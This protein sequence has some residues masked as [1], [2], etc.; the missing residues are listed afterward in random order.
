MSQDCT[1]DKLFVFPCHRHQMGWTPNLATAICTYSLYTHHSRPYPPPLVLI[2]RPHPYYSMPPTPSSPL[3]P[4]SRPKPSGPFQW[5]SLST[6]PSISVARPLPT[7]VP[8]FTASPV[9]LPSVIHPPDQCRPRTPYLLRILHSPC[10]QLNL[11]PLPN[12]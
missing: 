8:S 2:R 3:P 1:L 7:L 5:R 4:S 12:T 9:P 6:T 11:P 10:P